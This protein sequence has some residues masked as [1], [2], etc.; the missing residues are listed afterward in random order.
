MSALL[1]IHHLVIIMESLSPP[2]SYLLCQHHYCKSIALDV[3]MKTE[4]YAL[5]LEQSSQLREA[6]IAV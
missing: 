1:L 6:V 5:P 3:V 2:L 4:T